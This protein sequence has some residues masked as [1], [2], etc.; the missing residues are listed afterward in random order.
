[1]MLYHSFQNFIINNIP[2]R[3][4]GLSVSLLPKPVEKVT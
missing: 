4:F 3:E 1:M 2:R